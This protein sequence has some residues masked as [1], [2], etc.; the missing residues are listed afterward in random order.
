MTPRDV[1]EAHFRSADVLLRVYRLLESDEGPT[2]DDQM[3][4]KLR[5]VLSCRDD[6]EVILLM[7]QLFMGVVRERAEMNL[8]VL[9][10]GEP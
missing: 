1:F 3:I 8:G 9:P 5:K 4:P 10:Q 7:N 2:R 6:E